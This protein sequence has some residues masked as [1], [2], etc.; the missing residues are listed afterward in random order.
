MEMC[1]L[2]LI[3]L[4]HREAESR[5]RPIKLLFLISGASLGNLGNNYVY[6]MGR[7]YYTS[8]TKHLLYKMLMMIS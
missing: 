6:L 2:S 4:A 7:R 1:F 8:N 3:L 5:F